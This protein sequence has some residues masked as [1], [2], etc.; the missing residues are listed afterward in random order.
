[1]LGERA[2]NNI[3]LSLPESEPIGYLK[4]FVG[5]IVYFHSIQQSEE[6]NI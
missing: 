2:S 1:V 4:F 3:L 5:E 6:Q